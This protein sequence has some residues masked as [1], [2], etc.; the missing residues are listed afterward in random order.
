MYFQKFGAGTP[1]VFLH[2]WGCAGSIFIPVVRKLHGFKCY[3]PD[4]NG[5]G[6]SPCPPQSGWTVEQYADA[7]KIFYKQHNLSKTCIVAHSFG[8]RVAL[9]FAAKYP[10]SVSKMLLVAPAGLRHFSLKRRIKVIKYK[11]CK[12]FNAKSDVK[13]GSADYN[14]CSEDMRNTFVKVVN[15]DLSRFAKQTGCPVLIVNGNCDAETPLYQAR[16]LNKLIKNSS[17]VEIDGDHF[18]FFKHPSAFAQ[19]IEYFMGANG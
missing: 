14:S 15:Q 18:A 11:L 17:L 12:I 10:E 5:F 7:L 9:V 3:L 19:T 2:G 16:R 4:F 6:K 1:V 8:C 13:L